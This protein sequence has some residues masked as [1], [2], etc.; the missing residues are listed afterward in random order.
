MKWAEIT[1]RCAP[2]SVDAVT[3]L[4]TSLGCGGTVV[5]DGATGGLGERLE[6]VLQAAAGR[7]TLRGE[8]V[9]GGVRAAAGRSSVGAGP[10]DGVWHRRPPDNAALSGGVG[11]DSPA[12]RARP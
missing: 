6:G 4:L 2:A 12:W 7:A 8:A 10:R 1:L 9:V 5:H 3:A 11:G